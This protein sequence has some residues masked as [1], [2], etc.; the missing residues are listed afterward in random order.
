M[1]PD[2]SKKILPQ[3]YSI[4]ANTLAPPSEDPERYLR[5]TSKRLVL[6][7]VGQAAWAEKKWL[8]V[9]DAEEGFRSAF[10]VAEN[11]DDVTLEFGDGQ[12]GASHIRSVNFNN[13]IICSAAN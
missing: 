13:P 11:G 9:E 12:V 8:W 10:V 7:T 5:A 6:D 4:N 2:A 3:Q 1:T